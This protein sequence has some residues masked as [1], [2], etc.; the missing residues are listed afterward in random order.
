[1]LTQLTLDGLLGEQ[2]QGP[3]C[4]TFWRIRTGKR[5]DFGALLSINLKWTTRAWSVVQKAQACGS[6]AVTPA[7]DGGVMDL[8]RGGNIMECLAA[9]EFEQS[10]G[11]LELPS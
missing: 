2:A 8:E 11:A 4:V 10:G 6:V 5:S 9:V 1:M 3:A 7:G